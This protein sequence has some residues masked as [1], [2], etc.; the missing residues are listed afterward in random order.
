M[1][2]LVDDLVPLIEQV[3]NRFIHLVSSQAGNI[4]PGLIHRLPRVPEDAQPSCLASETEE[5][6]A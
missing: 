6:T 1:L 5:V 2:Q 3:F 4:Q